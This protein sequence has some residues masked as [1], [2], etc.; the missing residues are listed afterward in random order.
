MTADSVT[1]PARSFPAGQLWLYALPVLAAVDLGLMVLARTGVDL[2]RPR[3]LLIPGLVSFSIVGLSLAVARMLARGPAQ[4]A[5]IAVLLVMAVGTL[6]DASEALRYGSALHL[7]G[8]EPTVALLYVLAVTGPIL[9]ARQPTRP[10]LAWCWFAGL[11]LGLLFAFTT[12]SIVLQLGADLSPPIEP[13]IRSTPSQTRRPP[14]IYLLVMDKYTAP[15]LLERHY[16]L[17]VAPFEAWLRAHDFLIPQAHRSNYTLTFLTLASM[18]NLRYVDDYPAR[19]GATARSRMLAAPEIENN[20]LAAFLKERGY[21]F[22]F[23]PSAF[24]VTRRNRYADLQ[25]PDPRDVRADFTV[26]WYRSSA[27]PVLHRFACA[28]LGCEAARWPYISESADVL[29]AKFNRLA[30]LPRAD[31]PTFVLAHLLLPHE[32]YLYRADCSRRPPYWPAADTGTAA[33]AVRAA[34]AA[35]VSCTNRKLQVLIEALQRAAPVPPI[36]LIQG[37]H[38]HGRMG[39]PV[40]PLA[41]LPD[42][43]VEERL[44]PFAAY[45]LPGLPRDS[46]H[47]GITPVNVMR[48]VLRHYLGADLPRLE[49]ASYWSSTQHP[50]RFTRVQ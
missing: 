6:G 28:A 13:G 25:L 45:S 5:L 39:H 49:D 34:Y 40:L 41:R 50:Y 29:D 16:D 17:R 31:R 44:S 7:I 32:P 18:L 38:G 8:G 26:A 30:H 43:L 1:R 21:R 3:Y 37:D 48:L 20:R 19:F 24:D 9:A 27:L 11:T 46:L 35:Q 42:E 12:V 10:L 14:D 33:G 22:I 4:V 2:L 36:I 15:D 23:L 47:P